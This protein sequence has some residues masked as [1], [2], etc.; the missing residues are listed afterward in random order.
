[1]SQAPIRTEAIDRDPLPPRGVSVQVLIDNA[2]LEAI[3]EQAAQLALDQLARRTNAHSSPWL[4]GAAAA[5]DYLGWATERVYK[6]IRELPHYREGGLVMFRR[7]ELDAFV[8]EGYEGPTTWGSGA[9]QSASGGR[10]PAP[11]PFQ[12]DRRAHE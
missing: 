10:L 2:T 5:A 6:R 1:L 12:A 11:T 4:T 3:A 7:D 9:P 8:E